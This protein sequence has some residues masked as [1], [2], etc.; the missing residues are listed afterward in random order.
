MGSGAFVKSTTPPASGSSTKPDSG[1]AVAA[2]HK[3]DVDGSTAAHASAAQKPTTPA[4]ALAFH[5]ESAE[6]PKSG[7]N[8]GPSSGGIPAGEL[9]EP[10]CGRKEPSMNR[11]RDKIDMRGRRAELTSLLITCS[12]G[13]GDDVERE[14]SCAEKTEVHASAS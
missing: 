9:L 11:I 6:T 4:R 8:S 10:L 7:P 13:V 14:T 12:H 2:G 3:T 5:E 1:L